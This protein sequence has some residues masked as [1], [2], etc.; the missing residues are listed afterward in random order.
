MNCRGYTASN[1]TGRWSW[2]VT[3]ELEEDITVYYKISKYHLS[4]HTEWKNLGKCQSGCLVN[5]PRFELGTF[6]IQNYTTH[7]RNLVCFKMNKPPFYDKSMVSSK[8]IFPSL[9]PQFLSL[10]TLQWVCFTAVWKWRNIK[11]VTKN[12]LNENTW[13][14]L[15]DFV[16]K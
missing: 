15:S 5:Q 2:M 4:I 14:L 13:C 16:K 12:G 3:K 6:W 8:C 11:P 7:S 9:C 1:K 10:R